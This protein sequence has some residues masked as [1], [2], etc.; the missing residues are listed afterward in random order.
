MTQWARQG[1]AQQGAGLRLVIYVRS[2]SGGAGK[3]AVKYANILNALGYDTVLCCVRAPDIEQFRLVDGVRLH[4]FG[5][6]RNLAAIRPLRDV[7]SQEAPHICLVVDASNLYAMVLSLSACKRRPVLVLREAL[8]TKQR[9]ELRSPVKQVLK[10]WLHRFNYARCDLVIALTRE[11]MGE[12][13]NYWNLPDHKLCRI[14]NGVPVE[15]TKNPPIALRA[16]V[17][18]CVARLEEQKDVATLLRAFS[19][20]REAH[21]YTLE[22]AGD[23]RLRADLEALAA[24]LGIT[25]HVR[26]LGHVSDIKSLYANARLSVLP[27]L[28]EGFPN[29]VIEALAQ[30]TPVVATATPGAVEVLQDG[31]AGLICALADPADMAD[32]M[33]AAL[34]TNW[35]DAAILARAE[36]YSDARLETRVTDAFA[37]LAERVRQP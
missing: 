8:S 10:G 37:P 15:A 22:I 36:S 35:S 1:D 32:K 34:Q 14:P 11:M 31:Q 24:Q 5:A 28:W 23:G 25:S 21:D 27:S 20:L 9:L 26:F 13:R 4:V 29:V 18:V 2:I 30:G 16:R 7:L 19:I 17:I 6:R 33:R 3:N 12:L